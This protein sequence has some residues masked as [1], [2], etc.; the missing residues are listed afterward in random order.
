[1]M[2][3]ADLSIVTVISL[4]PDLYMDLVYT[5]SECTHDLGLSF[6]TGLASVKVHLTAEL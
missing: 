4:C 2:L 5:W 3:F 1:M 6:G